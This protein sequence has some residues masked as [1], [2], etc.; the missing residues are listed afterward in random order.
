MC[1]LSQKAHIKLQLETESYITEREE[2]IQQVKQLQEERSE[3]LQNKTAKTTDETF[4]EKNN[5]KTSSNSRSCDKSKTEN[6]TTNEHS[7]DDKSAT[8]SVKKGGIID[9]DKV[10][11]LAIIIIVNIGFII[12]SSSYIHIFIRCSLT[13]FAKLNYIRLLIVYINSNTRHLL[14]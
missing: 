4:D 8:A 13:G 7:N 3:D 11:E 5:N 1:C 2:A 6:V 10:N 12:T 9:M 14:T